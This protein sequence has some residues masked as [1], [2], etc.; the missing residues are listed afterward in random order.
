MGLYNPTD[1]PQLIQKSTK[2]AMIQQIQD[3]HVTAYTIPQETNSE[4]TTKLHSVNTQ[5][6]QNTTNNTKPK[7]TIAELRIQIP[8]TI[9]QEMQHR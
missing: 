6:Q 2:I 1:T 9:P 8:E 4:H 3:N 7:C 5:T